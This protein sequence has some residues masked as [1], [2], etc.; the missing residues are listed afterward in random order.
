MMDE[1]SSPIRTYATNSAILEPVLVYECGE[2]Y[3]IGW[4]P[5]VS[6]H[7][8]FPVLSGRRLVGAYP[9]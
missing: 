3:H 2:V 6:G 4:D 5:V 8:E 1:L 9:N 7:V